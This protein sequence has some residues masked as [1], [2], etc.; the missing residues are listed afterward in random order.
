MGLS[1]RSLPDS[2]E[3]LESLKKIEKDMLFLGILIF[4][5]CLQTTS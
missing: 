2:D 1:A 5:N 3:P 4:E